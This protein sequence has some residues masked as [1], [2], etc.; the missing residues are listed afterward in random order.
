MIDREREAERLEFLHS[1]EIPDSGEEARFTELVA[2]ICKVPVAMI[3]LV[4]KNRQW[5]KA[6]IGFSRRETSLEESICFFAILDAD[7]TVIPDISADERTRGMALS[8]D[9]APLRFYTGAPLVSLGHMAI[10]TL[11]ILD[12]SP[13]QLT[14]LQQRALRV[15]ADQV[16]AQIELRAAMLKSKRALESK[17]TR[18]EVVEEEKEELQQNLNGQEMLNQEIDHRVKNSLQL[19]T[20]ML[21][22]QAN[23]ADSED[24]QKALEAVQNRVAA[25]ASVHAELDRSS[26][27]DRINLSSYVTNLAADLALSTPGN[28]Q[29]RAAVEPMTIATSKA[30][31]VAIIVN[32]FVANSV[33]YAFPDH[34]AG[35]I[36]VTIG[37]SGETV[38]FQLRDDGIGYSGGF[39]SPSPKGLGMRIMEA[40][41]RQLDSKLRFGEEEKGTVLTIRFSAEALR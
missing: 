21:R 7:V 8:E 41:A 30:T 20:S 31:S 2:A 15:L 34:R 5:F 25:I 17:Q 35:T 14:D 12:T 32:E 3:S 16:M 33:K 38:V 37:R 22:F 39:D 6:R 27:T 24:I 26:E 13:R 19:V 29:I 28:I 10:G 4:D 18:L 36:S 40:A 23:K 1:L 11:C 9:G